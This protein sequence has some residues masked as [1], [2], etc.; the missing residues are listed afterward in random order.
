MFLQPES[1]WSSCSEIWP[2]D[3]PEYI[4]KDYS[5][6]ELESLVKNNK[7]QGEDGSLNPIYV[8]QM[9]HLCILLDKQWDSV[10]SKFCVTQVCDKHGQKLRETET[11]FSIILKKSAWLPALKC[12]YSLSSEGRMK[13]TQEVVLS[14]PSALYLRSPEVEGLLS[15]KVIYLDAE[16]KSTSFHQYLRITHSIAIETIKNFL[17]SWSE[18]EKPELPAVFFTSLGHIKNVYQYLGNHLS[19][20]E[21]QNLLH[22]KPVIFVPNLHVG[23]H[24]DVVVAGKMLSRSEVWISDRTGLF[25]KHRDLLNDYHIDLGQKRTITCYYEDRPDILELFKAEGKIDSQPRVEE[26]IELQALLCSVNTPK[27]SRA[28]SDVLHI[29]ATIGKALET[30]PDDLSA[31]LAADVLKSAI[32]KKLLTQKVG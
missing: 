6:I 23:L 20:H 1:Y 12:Q 32:K 4:V 17:L 2:K 7:Y 16:L 21:L 11:S 29:F 27:D 8:E 5:C 25:D 14:E 18:R 26:Y 22:E 31:K 10:Y 30:R 28:L 24:H 3:E 13:G 19:K 15:D 9:R